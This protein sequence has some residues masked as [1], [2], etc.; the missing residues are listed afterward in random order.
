MRWPWTKKQNA[1]IDEAPG[2]FFSRFGLVLALGGILVLAALSVVTLLM[3]K[4]SPPPAAPA[5]PVETSVSGS[6][7]LPPQPPASSSADQTAEAAPEEQPAPPSADEGKTDIVW[8]PVDQPASA[9]PLAPAGPETTPDVT[10]SSGP[11]GELA[12]PVIPELVQP[13]PA[14]Q[15]ETQ[16]ETGSNATAQ[17]EAEPFA[18]SSS[19]EKPAAAA[20]PAGTLPEPRWK[21][22]DEQWDKVKVSPEEPPFEDLTVPGADW[23]Q[24]NV[25]Q[26]E[27]VQ[28]EQ[29]DK[30]VETAPAM[31]TDAKADKT[32]KPQTKP[33]VKPTVAAAGKPSAKAPAKPAAS[34]LK[35]AVFNESGQPGQ[36]EIY[37]DVL[38][39]M[40]YKVVA[41]G[42]R[43]PQPGP[44][45]LLYS[46]GRQKEAM[47]LLGRIPGQKNASPNPGK[48]EYD[49]VI[50]VR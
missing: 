12:H 20:A 11:I 7:I 25:G 13:Q 15:T 45:T 40:G 18:P 32:P 34:G 17:P 31:K 23:K 29:L 9:E 14:P 26:A 35:I 39:A 38:K 24:I 10:A 37:R 27:K 5:A 3:L 22:V 47:A 46:Q 43:V 33:P 41:V 16:P 36:A 30:A 2:G 49:V 50:L 8:P 4:K 48:S 28:G 6:V 19:T 44:T 42:D 21:T 1:I